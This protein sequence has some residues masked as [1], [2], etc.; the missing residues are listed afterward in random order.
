MK[1]TGVHIHNYYPTHCSINSF[2]RQNIVHMANMST[3]SVIADEWFPSSGLHVH[4]MAFGCHGHSAWTHYCV[5]HLLSLS[6]HSDCI[7]KIAPYIRLPDHSTFGHVQL[8]S[9]RFSLI[10][11]IFPRYSCIASKQAIH[12]YD[13]S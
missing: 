12:S 10:F 6:L 13:C 9:Y 8:S 3:C 2:C 5:E 1:N 11:I 4:E 7:K